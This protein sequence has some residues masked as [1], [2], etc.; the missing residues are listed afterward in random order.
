MQHFTFLDLIEHVFIRI[1]KSDDKL[2]QLV[3]HRTS[4]PVMVSC[5]FNPYWSKLYFLLKRF[6]I[7]AN[8]VQKCQKCQICVIYENFDQFNAT[9][10]KIT[11]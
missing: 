6:K 3:K 10:G 5:E 2:A 11:S 8:F 4:K 9:K 7:D 1:W